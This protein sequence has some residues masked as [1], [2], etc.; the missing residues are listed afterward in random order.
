M[1]QATEFG[2][3]VIVASVQEIIRRGLREPHFTEV[4]QDGRPASTISA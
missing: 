3:Q 1:M 4:L 2:F